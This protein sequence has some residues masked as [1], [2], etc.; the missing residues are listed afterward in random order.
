[1]QSQN[2][3]VYFLNKRKQKVQENR[4]FLKAMGLSW[5]NLEFGISG[6]RLM[7]LDEITDRLLHYNPNLKSLTGFF[8]VTNYFLHTN[9][10]IDYGKN[11]IY[12]YRFQQ[13]FDY[14]SVELRYRLRYRHW[15]TCRIIPTRKKDT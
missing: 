4:Q 2:I 9:Y 13:V 14:V 6:R 5:L 3:N 7:T 1:M 15:C 11:D 10:I 12:Y 8:N